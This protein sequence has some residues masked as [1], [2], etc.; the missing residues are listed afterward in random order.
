MKKIVIYLIAG[1]ITFL[2]KVMLA[3]KVERPGPQP[4]V[5]N[6][7]KFK[8]GIAGYTFAKIDIDRTLETFQRMDL[9]YFTIKDFHLP[10]NSTVEQ[11]AAFKEKL[12]SKGVIGYAVGPIYMKSESEVDRAFDYAKKLGVKLIIGVPD[13]E[14]LP[15]VNNKVKEY[16]I[17]LAIH[18]HGPE[19]ALY[20]APSDVYNRIKNL[21]ARMGM[22][23]DIG[24]SLRAGTLPEKAIKLYKDRLFD[25]HI[26]D[27]NSA[28]KDGKGI[29]IGRG[30]ININA[31]IESL[32]K[33]NYTGYCSIE[34]EKDM[35]DPLPGIA[36]S[37][38]YFKGVMNTED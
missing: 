38:G 27:I 28:T 5:E 12:Q 22:C 3:Q 14:L 8:L 33:I 20:P 37:I 7:E 36:E 32:K 10:L 19:D 30:V 29:E 9:H 31:V 35:T 26:K 11:I 6:A 23:I 17:K 21:D 16:D 24:H 15:Y 4:A 34:F 2:P 18:N 25:I 1:F 13:Y